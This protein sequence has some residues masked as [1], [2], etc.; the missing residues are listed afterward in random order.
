MD[1]ILHFTALDS[2]TAAAV[3]LR[4]RSQEGG[5]RGILRTSIMRNEKMEACVYTCQSHIHTIFDRQHIIRC[6]AEKC[7]QVAPVDAT[8]EEIYSSTRTIRSN[9]KRLWRRTLRALLGPST[10]LTSSRTESTIAPRIRSQPQIMKAP[11]QYP[12]LNNEIMRL[13]GANLKAVAKNAM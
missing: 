12:A 10:V 9:E 13:S 2:R 6:F 1:F 4:S 3:A 8:Y 5:R 7:T 11:R